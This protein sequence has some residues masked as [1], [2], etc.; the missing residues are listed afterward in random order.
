MYKRQTIY[1]TYSDKVVENIVI[2]IVLVTVL[3]GVIGWILLLIFPTKEQ[4]LGIK[5]SQRED[6]D[7][8]I[9]HIFKITIIV[10][11]LWL[12]MCIRDSSISATPS[13]FM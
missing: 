2:D 9:F 6:I 12:E 13:L 1:A 5:K 4:N 11:A 3:G 8:D 10:F 7:K